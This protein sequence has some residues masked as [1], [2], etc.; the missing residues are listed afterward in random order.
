MA[1]LGTCERIGVDIQA[2]PARL[3]AGFGGAVH[4]LY[5]VH[6]NVWD[7]GIAGIGSSAY[8]M[9]S[10]VAP[11]DFS[12]QC[13]IC[14][15]SYA[16]HRHAGC[17]RFYQSRASLGSVQTCLDWAAYHLAGPTVWQ[18]LQHASTRAPR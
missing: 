1:N 7:L 13:L 18:V 3:Y 10:H 5:F 2:Q 14:Q 9:Q 11:H 4:T 16:V 6:H 17:G 15:V 12:R 8:G